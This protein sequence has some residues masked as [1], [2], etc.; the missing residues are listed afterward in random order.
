MSLG[1]GTVSCYPTRLR[2]NTGVSD[3]RELAQAV[4]QGIL[5]DPAP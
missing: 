3:C 1:I 2:A 5:D 4:R